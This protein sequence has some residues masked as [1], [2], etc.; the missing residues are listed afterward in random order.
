MTISERKD[1]GRIVLEVNGRVDTST[2]EQ[3]Q[4]VILAALHKEKHVT[5]DFANVPYLSSAGLRA[6][7]LGHKQA[8]SK[9]ALMELANPTDFVKSVLVSVGFDKVLHIIYDQ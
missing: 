7:L 8:L 6:L 5:V 9:G 4:E 1:N 2:S 3:L